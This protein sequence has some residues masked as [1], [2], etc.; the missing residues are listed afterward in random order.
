MLQETLYLSASTFI[1]EAH[2]STQLPPSFHAGG[3]G[4]PELASLSHFFH[5]PELSMV[6][7]ALSCF[8]QAIVGDYAGLPEKHNQ[9]QFGS[10]SSNF[11]DATVPSKE[12]VLCPQKVK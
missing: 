5:F 10:P 3:L 4:H 6:S 9:V 7:G 11:W 1:S 2:F 12:V 8:L